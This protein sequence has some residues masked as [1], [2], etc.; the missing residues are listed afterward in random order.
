MK[1][2][3]TRNNKIYDTVTTENQ[4]ESTGRVQKAPLVAQPVTLNINQS[5]QEK[6]VQAPSN[7]KGKFNT[8]KSKNKKF[9][10]ADISNPTNFRVVQHVGLSTTSNN[11]EVLI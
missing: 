4:Y 3:Q 9:S 11:F 5:S 8:L 1:R 2:T 7:D 10:K 6:P